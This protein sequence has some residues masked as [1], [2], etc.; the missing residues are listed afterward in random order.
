M[1]AHR[2]RLL[3]SQDIAIKA[4]APFISKAGGET[5]KR[6][7]LKVTVPAS[8]CKSLGSK[9]TP[10]GFRKYSS[11]WPTHSLL[12]LSAGVLEGRGVKEALAPSCWCSFQ[13]HP[14][15]L[16][17]ALAS[18]SSSFRHTNRSPASLTQAAAPPQRSGSQFPGLL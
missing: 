16:P 15:L 11:S 14:C 3:W 17:A 8:S 5:I 1:V 12:G 13:C 10:Q 6:F 2:S 18:V 4:D 7:F 9:A